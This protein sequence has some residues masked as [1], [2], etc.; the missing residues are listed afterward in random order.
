MVA[1]EREEFVS[2][3]KPKRQRIEARSIGHIEA[4]DLLSIREGDNGITVRGI[5]RQFNDTYYNARRD[6]TSIS[7]S[8]VQRHFH[9]KLQWTIK[10]ID[11][12]HMEQSEEEQLLYMQEI[13]PFDT[14]NLKD[15]DAMS[16][17]PDQFKQY[18]GYAPKG[19]RAVRLQITLGTRSFSS[20]C[21][22]GVEAV[23]AVHIEEGII[24]ENVFSQFVLQH[25][26][27]VIIPGEIGLLD[28]ATVHKTLQSLQAL[29]TAFL[30]RF[31]FCFTYCLHLKPIE[32][33]F[34]LVKKYLRFH[35]VIATGNPIF[36]INKAF[37]LFKF[38]GPRQNEI[39][40]L[41]NIYFRNHASFLLDL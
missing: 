9:D 4:D 24:E 6:Y 37:D 36:W 5:T 10:K 38:G 29:N 14:N 32:K 35:E 28:N 21:M 19:D 11:H 8:T 26:R 18:Y 22:M 12:R 27:P 31:V 7:F 17:S 15:I 2:K 1:N 25:V 30:G 34:A 33:F 40:P 20:I 41:W 23:E 3:P 16:M 39:R 13:A